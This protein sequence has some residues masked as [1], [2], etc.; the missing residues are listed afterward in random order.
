MIRYLV[1]FSHTGIRTYRVTF[2]H[3]EKSRVIYVPG[4][5]RMETTFN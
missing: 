1:A 3:N 4:E 2:T 5:D